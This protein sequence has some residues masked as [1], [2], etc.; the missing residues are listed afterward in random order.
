MA[1]Q[2]VGDLTAAST[3]LA[4]TELVH[5]VQSGNSRKV[6]VDDIAARAGGGGDHRF[7]YAYFDSAD[8]SSDWEQLSQWVHSTD[9]NS[10]TFSSISGAYKDL[11]LVCEGLALST[12]GVGTSKVDFLASVNGG[13][14]YFEL[15]GS[16]LNSLNGATGVKANLL[17]LGYAQT[18]AGIVCCAA[19]SASSSGSNV[20]GFTDTQINKQ[21]STDQ[22]AVDGVRVSAGDG[23]FT[24]GTITLY[25]KA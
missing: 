13:T 20:D 18:S 23:D 10:V 4:G 12:P 21:P 7:D 1:N 14:N 5:I 11:L 8:R 25:A 3:P 9:V 2:E 15:S 16:I 19:G 6:A 24:S 22:T 17:I